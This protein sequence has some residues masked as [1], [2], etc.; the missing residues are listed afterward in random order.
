M[1]EPTPH[2]TRPIPAPMVSIETKP[3]WDAAAE[4]RLVVPQCEHCGGWQ[5]PPTADCNQ[6]G[7][8]QARQ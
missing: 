1:S 7:S 5:W 2:M 6:C 4:H 3:F 8:L